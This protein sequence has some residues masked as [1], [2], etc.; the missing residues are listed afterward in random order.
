MK[1]PLLAYGIFTHSTAG[2]YLSIRF[3]VIWIAPEA[4]RPVFPGTVTERWAFYWSVYQSFVYF[5]YN[6]FL[7]MMREPELRPNL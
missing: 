2:L 3:W 7:W 1:R 4:A 5:Y 6:G